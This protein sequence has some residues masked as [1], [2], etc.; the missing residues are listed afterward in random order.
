MA[1]AYATAFMVMG[2]ENSIEFLNE[3]WD[4]DLEVYFIYEEDGQ[5]RT[6]VTEKLADIAIQP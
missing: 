4:L 2:L 3:N 1:D 5:I 6:A